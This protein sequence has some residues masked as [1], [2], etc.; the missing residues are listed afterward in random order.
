MWFETAGAARRVAWDKV[1]SYTVSTVF[2]AINHNF[3]DYEGA[4][5]LWETM[6]FDENGEEAHCLRY[7]TREEAEQGHKTVVEE[8]R[9]GNL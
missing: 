6:V 2:L 1:G 9:N 3:G 4:P 8:L 5:I 7:R